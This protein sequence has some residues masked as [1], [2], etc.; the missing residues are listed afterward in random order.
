[1]KFAIV[2]GLLALACPSLGFSQSSI[3]KGVEI[4]HSDLELKA[5]TQYRY[6][7]ECRTNLIPEGE[8]LRRT[9]RNGSFQESGRGSGNK[10]AAHFVVLQKTRVKRLTSGSKVQELVS[11]PASDWSEIFLIA[12]GTEAQ[13][14]ED[15][16]LEGDYLLGGGLYA[17]GFLGVD[18]SSNSAA[19]ASAFL[20]LAT[21]IKSVVDNVDLLGASATENSNALVD[22]RAIVDAYVTFEDAL[23]KDSARFVT[24]E[25]HLGENVVRTGYSTVA[26][27]VTEHA[28]FLLE[29][30]IP[31]RFDAP[32][33]LANSLKD[34]AIDASFKNEMKK[35]RAQLLGTNGAVGAIESQ[36]ASISRKIRDYGFYS[37]TDRAYLLAE[38]LASIGA[39]VDQ[40]VICF[41]GADLVDEMNNPRVRNLIAHRDK[42]VGRGGVFYEPNVAL[43]E[44]IYYDFS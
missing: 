24:K 4:V 27:H 41:K 14:F 29:D 10:S 31:F 11:N 33:L 43:V 38:Y 19:I 13:H 30:G 12:N 17:G 32:K 25:L 1:M 23:N 5:G 26:I 6:E 15:G 37:A 22:A 3:P 8:F 36:C 2:V 34:F 20:T 7:V 35:T 44:Q 21:T 9:R 42:G 40:R 18:S 39:F 16:C 28:S